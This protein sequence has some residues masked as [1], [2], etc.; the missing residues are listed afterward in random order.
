MT[1][2]VGMD[3]FERASMDTRCGRMVWFGSKNSHLFNRQFTYM[4]RVAN[5][6]MHG[7]LHSLNTWKIALIG[8]GSQEVQHLWGAGHYSV[9][10]ENLEKNPPCNAKDYLHALIVIEAWFGGY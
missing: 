8:R 4:A 7:S 1:S 3:F 5:L 10:I 6:K 2:H 9:D